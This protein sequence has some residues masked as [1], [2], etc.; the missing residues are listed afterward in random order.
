M[1]KKHKRRA[2]Q[3]R[4]GKMCDPACCDNCIYIGEG[5]F[6]CDAQTDP[7]DGGP[8]FVMSDWEATEFY[9]GCEHGSRKEL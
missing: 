4:H 6:I 9:M 1:G 3:H 5:D 2:A 8:V 7:E